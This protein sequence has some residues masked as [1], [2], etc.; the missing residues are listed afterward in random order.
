MEHF[1][2]EKFIGFHL[3]LI[4]ADIIFSILSG[5][6]DSLS[7]N[8]IIP[9]L[10]SLLDNNISNLKWKIGKNEKDI[11]DLGQFIKDFIRLILI[12]FISFQIYTFFKKYKRYHKL[13]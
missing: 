12:S 1:N 6:I 11:I 10:D 2:Y 3:Y 5:F 13:K 4:A 9:L 8:F 7:T